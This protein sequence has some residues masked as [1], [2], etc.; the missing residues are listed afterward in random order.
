[1]TYLYFDIETELPPEDWD[2]RSKVGITCASALVVSDF[3]GEPVEAYTT[4]WAGMEQVPQ[5]DRFLPLRSG[6]E[7]DVGKTEELMAAGLL[8]VES[9]MTPEEVELMFDNL[10]SLQASS[11][12]FGSNQLFTWN[13]VGFDFP[14]IASNIPHRREEIAAMALRSFDPCVQF[15]H[16]FGFP[17]GLD[18]VAQLMLGEGKPEGMDGKKA[19]QVWP[20]QAAEVLHYVQ[21]DVRIL[22]MAVEAM[23][24]ARQ[25]RWITR[26]GSERTR[27]LC[28]WHRINN[29]MKLSEPDRSWMTSGYDGSY[30]LERV[31]A[32][33]ET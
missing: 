1:V 25:V 33:M 14:I 23:M 21:N 24:E 7:V 27:G 10:L 22:R 12:P 32:W 30:D 3:E 17:I 16:T 8:L 28:G 26:N 4:W 11:P 2:R 13:G 29:L 31:M 20:I 5:N 18:K 9:K 6:G 15:M 19:A